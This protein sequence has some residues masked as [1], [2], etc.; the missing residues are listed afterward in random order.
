MQVSVR[1]PGKKKI[2]NTGSVANKGNPGSLQHSSFT[3][4][5]K[6]ANDPQTLPL[7]T[8]YFLPQDTKE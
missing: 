8:P 2:G 7:L 5:L 6:R 4:T 3:E 1:F